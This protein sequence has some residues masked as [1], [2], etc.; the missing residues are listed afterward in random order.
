[1][2]VWLGLQQGNKLRDAV[3]VELRID[4]QHIRHH[5]EQR[6]RRE[7]LFRIIRLGLEN[8]RVEGVGGNRAHQD[9]VSVGFGAG[10][11]VRTKIA[12]GA[13]DIFNDDL[14][15]EFITHLLRDN[16][17][18]HIGR[19]AR[20]ERN[21]QS[22]RSLGEALRARSRSQHAQRNRCGGKFQHCSPF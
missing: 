22:N 18:D 13:G 7:I 12:A 16:T 2:F 21:D 5:H 10:H 4:D 1:M 19:A 6:D 20:R 8:E 15:A 11:A 9:R 3:D 17:R 14:L